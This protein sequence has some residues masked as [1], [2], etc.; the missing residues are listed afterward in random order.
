MLC[1]WRQ[2][3][4]YRAVDGEQ[5]K[6]FRAK[7]GLTQQQLAAALSVDRNTVARWERHERMIPAFL[8]LAL[9]TLERRKGSTSGK[10]IK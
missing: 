5:L 10:R 6:R 2:A 4:Y 3:C 7:L 9:E 1:Q 8:A